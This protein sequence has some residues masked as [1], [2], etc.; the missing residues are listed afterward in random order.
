MDSAA[1]MTQAWGIVRQSVSPSLVLSCIVALVTFNLTMRHMV[2]SIFAKHLP[3]GSPARAALTRAALLVFV[4]SSAFRT[5]VT[6]PDQVFPHLQSF[7]LAFTRQQARR[8]LALMAPAERSFLAFG[9]GLDYTVLV[10]YSVLYMLLCV[11]HADSDDNLEV[12][13]LQLFVGLAHA[14]QNWFALRTLA[15]FPNDITASDPLYMSAC[16]VIKLF[17]CSVVWCFLAFKEIEERATRPGYITPL[18]PRGPRPPPN[19]ELEE[20]EGV[21]N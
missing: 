9:L 19:D 5:Y 13:A 1:V 15:R 21:G 17:L 4:V 2:R 10:S 3:R 16:C 11:R 12:A 20:D 14:L 7:E 8:T 18:I 6:T